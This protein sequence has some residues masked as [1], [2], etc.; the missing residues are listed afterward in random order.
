MFISN[1]KA[2]LLGFTRRDDGSMAI[3]AMIVLPAMFWSLLVSFS[4]FD[5][6]RMYSINQKAAYTIGDSISR[7]TAPVD[8]E[9]L[10][11]AH[12]MFEYLTLSPGEASLRVSSLRYDED[13]D[14]FFAD[15]SQARGTRPELSDADVQGYTDRLPFLPDG[16]RV[17]LVETWSTYDPP[18][19]TGLEQREIQNFVFTR[20]RFAPR[21]CWEACD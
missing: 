17:I 7:E 6:F 14:R 9:Y 10:T 20:P 2:R 11:G 15:W 5:T 16:E 13:Q 19:A 8:G 12:Q 18:F 21:V 4:L 1:L 3:E